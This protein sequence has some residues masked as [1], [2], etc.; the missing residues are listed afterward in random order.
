MLG[1]IRESHLRSSPQTSIEN[2]SDDDVDTVLDEEGQ[3]MKRNTT[4]FVG[5]YL[6][7]NGVDEGH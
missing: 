2:D 7:R 5:N 4:K 6:K 1:H 3:P